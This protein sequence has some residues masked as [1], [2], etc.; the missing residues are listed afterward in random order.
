MRSGLIGEAAFADPAYDRVNMI[1]YPERHQGTERACQEDVAGPK[2]FATVDRRAK[3]TPLWSGPL[4]S[5]RYQAADL[6][7]VL[8]CNSSNCTGLK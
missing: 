1:P 5:D 6:T 8:A 4:G 3:R 7:I 2:W